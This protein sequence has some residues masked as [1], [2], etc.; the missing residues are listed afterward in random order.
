MDGTKGIDPPK[1]T[2]NSAAAAHI[3]AG[4]FEISKK[5]DTA[6]KMQHIAVSRLVPIL[7]EKAPMPKRPIVLAT[8]I[9][10]IIPAATSAVIPISVA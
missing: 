7:S 4:T 2:P 6:N 10:L 1:P 8:P 9:A 3:K 5:H